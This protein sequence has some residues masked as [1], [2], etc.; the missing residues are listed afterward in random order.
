MT[1]CAGTKLSTRNPCTD[2][3]FFYPYSLCRGK[4]FIIILFIVFFCLTGCSVIRKQYLYNNTQ[5]GIFKTAASPEDT[6]IN[7]ECIGTLKF[8][9][10]Q[11]TAEGEA[12]YAAAFNYTYIG[13]E[14]IIRADN[15][16]EVT[17]DNLKPFYLP[18]KK[19]PIIIK[20]I[21][22][23]PEY[24]HYYDGQLTNNLYG[25]NERALCV[26]AKPYL[27]ALVKA[28]SVRITLIGGLD[29]DNNI[30]MTRSF[31]FGEGTFEDV[32]IFYNK[33]VSGKTAVAK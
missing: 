19:V 16:V 14:F 9:I 25:T 17:V 11:N 21:Y 6:L 2:K 27:D 1:Y 24:F 29:K 23:N 12:F 8:S 32:R 13:N 10:I 7:Y 20:D 5:N 31:L 3:N 18:Y 4:K 26:L 33:Y 15:A 30:P 28:K 22:L